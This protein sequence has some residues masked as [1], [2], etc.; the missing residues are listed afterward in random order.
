[1]LVDFQ[2][3]P[4]NYFERSAYYAEQ[5]VRKPVFMPDIGGMG[6]G[7][8][9]DPSF[10]VQRRGGYSQLSLIIDDSKPFSDALSLNLL[11]Y[12]ELMQDIQRGFGRTMSHLTKIFGVSRQTLYNWLD[13]E[14]PKTQHQNKII[15]LAVAARVFSDVGFKPSAASFDRVIYQGKS[16]AD[17]F[18]SNGDGRDVAERLIRL[19]QK[20]RETKLK[21][22]EMLGERS[23]TKE[24][25][26]KVGRKSFD[27]DMKLNVG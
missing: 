12:A 18:I 23:K 9:Q 20:S 3:L 22:T 6:T 4:H 13:G 14:Q 17:L 2:D 5:R 26:L 15:Q 21:L 25:T 19:E 11:S 10:H 27:E 24:S 16:F 8:Y 1:M 7:G